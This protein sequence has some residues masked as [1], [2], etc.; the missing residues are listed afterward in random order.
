MNQTSF[1]TS[2]MCVASTLD[3]LLKERSRKSTSRRPLNCPLRRDDR[4]LLCRSRRLSRLQGIKASGTNWARAPFTT[5]SCFN[6]EGAADMLNISLD[7]AV[8]SCPSIFRTDRF[9]KFCNSYMRGFSD[10]IHSFQSSKT[11]K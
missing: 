7:R 9:P 5:D 6:W 4:E 8:I 10:F 11:R 2:D 1:P 3:M